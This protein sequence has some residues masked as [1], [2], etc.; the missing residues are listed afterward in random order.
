MKRLLC[1]L[2][3]SFATFIPQMSRGASVVT[4]WAG[5]T[6]GYTQRDPGGAAGPSG[7]FEVANS[8]IS[9]YTKAGILV[10]TTNQ[11]AFFPPTSAGDCKAVYDMISQRFFA[12]AIGSGGTQ[13]VV[14]V[15]RNSNPATSG[16]NDWRFYTF[17]A[18]TGIDYPGIG[19]DAQAFYVSYYGGS[20]K[21]WMVMNKT[22][23][24]SGVTNAATAQVVTNM[25]TA[26]YSAN[27]GL[28][29]V[30]VVGATSPGDIAYCVTRDT[31][32]NTV[33][34]FAITN[35]LGNRVFFQTNLPAPPVG[36]NNG[37]L[38]PQLGTA[39]RLIAG[40]AAAMG[41]AFWREGELWFCEAVGS[42][43][44]QERS[45][46]RYYKIKTSGFPNGQATLDEAGDLDG[47]ANTWCLHPSIAGNPRGDV[48][49]VFSQSSSNS[50]VSMRSAIRK[51]GQTTFDT[52][53]V[54][55]SS[56]NWQANNS[57]SDFSVVTSDPND[58]TFWASH[59]I[60]NGN[61]PA[62]VN[63]WWG[64]IARDNLFFVD[65]N[66]VGT[67]L[68]TRE[69]PYHTVRNAHTAV[70]GA[71]TLVIKPASY[72]EPTLP[73]RL[74]KNVRLENPYPSGIVHIGP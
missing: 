57:W 73:L 70:T 1:Y 12:A 27:F 10:W 16:T 58:Q 7:I 49:L 8:D 24:L 56:T 47:G 14:A 72:P 18:G 33:A 42:T 39:N 74:D 32:S 53:V 19:I 35:V 20:P 63:I 37:I 23:L 17:A 5:S 71:K 29:A 55:T 45:V 28:Q 4:N 52:V 59:L 25:P 31:V 46:I 21:F 64:N 43:N 62:S 61:N 3:A 69:L 11:Q 34:L 15:S 41:N 22:N 54:K 40:T 60:I 50:F 38:A 2:L 51:V 44:Q 68:G 48:C 65:K 66:A 9:Y 30:S 36:T 26:P 13:I 67:E 6:A